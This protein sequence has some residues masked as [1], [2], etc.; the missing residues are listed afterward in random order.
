VCDAHGHPRQASGRKNV[1]LPVERQL[2]LPFGQIDEL[3]LGWVD[4]RGHE[5]A[6]LANDLEGEGGVAHL[7]EIVGLSQDLPD[8]ASIPLPREGNARI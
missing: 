7:F 6:G 1:W 2:H 4:M 8:G 3:V 5:S